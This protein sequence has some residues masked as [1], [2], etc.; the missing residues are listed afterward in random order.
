V[1]YIHLIAPGT[2]DETVYQ[3]LEARQDAVEAA[4]REVRGT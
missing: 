2:V 1:T 3:A 4:L